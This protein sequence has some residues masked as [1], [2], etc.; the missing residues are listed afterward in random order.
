MSMVVLT[1]KQ[2]TLFWSLHLYMMKLKMLEMNQKYLERQTKNNF[3]W[4]SM[5]CKPWRKENL[6]SSKGL[7]HI[8]EEMKLFKDKCMKDNVTFP[9]SL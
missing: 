5:K 2:V 1:A 4:T 7:S 8:Y 9:K 3:R 6:S